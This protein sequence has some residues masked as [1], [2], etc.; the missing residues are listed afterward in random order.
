MFGW[1]YAVTDVF[2]RDLQ[3]GITSATDGCESAEKRGNVFVRL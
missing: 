2:A 1:F 3:E